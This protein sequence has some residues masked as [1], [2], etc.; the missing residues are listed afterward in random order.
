MLAYQ[1]HLVASICMTKTQINSMRSHLVME[2]VQDLVVCA[3][4][5]IQGA[6]PF[7][8]SEFTIS[9]M[10][11]KMNPLYSIKVVPYNL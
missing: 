4:Y 2:V 6:K 10:Q 5:I 7:I 9:W 8:E 3:K 1:P 11:A